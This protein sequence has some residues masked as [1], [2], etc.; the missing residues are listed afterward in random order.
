M[1]LL[2]LAALTMIAFE[3][4]R[5]GGTDPAHWDTPTRTLLT[6]WFGPP[7]KAEEDAFSGFVDRAVAAVTS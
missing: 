5:R 1:K 4:A 6:A 2:G 3:I 7:S